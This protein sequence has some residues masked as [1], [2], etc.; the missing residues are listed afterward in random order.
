M[1]GFY[2]GTLGIEVKSKNLKFWCVWC[3]LCEKSKLANEVVVSVKYS[4]FDQVAIVSCSIDSNR[5][6]RLSHVG[7]ISQ[8]L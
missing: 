8:D 1:L 7:R 3:A 4:F 6:S 5:A 2:T